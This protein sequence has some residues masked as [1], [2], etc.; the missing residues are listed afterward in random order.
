MK[1]DYIN[2][3]I[4]DKSIAIL[5][6]NDSFASIKP[7][8]KISLLQ[9]I[10]DSQAE[11]IRVGMNNKE[12]IRILELGSLKVKSGREYVLAERANICKELGISDYG[13]ANKE[14]KNR[15]KVILNERVRKE[16][17]ERKLDNKENTPF[18]RAVI[19][20]SGSLIQ[21]IKNSLDK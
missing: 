18:N 19:I 14:D 8:N 20:N 4:L 13:S 11:M 2:N 21:K 10:F 12:D 15:V 17:L 7:E 6:S 16:F 5:N 3:R 9:A 1:D